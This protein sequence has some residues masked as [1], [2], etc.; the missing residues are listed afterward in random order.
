MMLAGMTLPTTQ[1]I[2]NKIK[3]INDA[4]NYHFREDDVDKVSISGIVL[5]F[6]CCMKVVFHQIKK[7]TILELQS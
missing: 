5:M 1:E 3:D 2:E 4:L 7:H 6:V